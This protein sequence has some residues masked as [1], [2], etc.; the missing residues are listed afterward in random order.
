MQSQRFLLTLAAAAALAG[1]ASA[2]APDPRDPWEPLNRATFQVNDT[3]DRAVFKPLAQGYRFVLPSPIRTG[4]R[5]VFANLQDPWIAVNQLLQGKA[6]DALSDLWRFIA[7]STFGLG[8]V[9][10]IATDM[11]MPKHNEDFGQTLAVWGVGFG[12][13]LVL[14]ILGPSTVRDAAGTGVGA[15]VDY[16]PWKIPK[17]FNFEHRVAW[18]NSLFALDFVQLRASLLDTTAALE[19]AALDPYAFLRGAYFQRRR[20]LIYDGNPPP[21]DASDKPSPEPPDEP[22]PDAPRGAAD[23]TPLPA[24][25][26]DLR[27][28]APDESARAI[29][30]KVPANYE[31]VLEAGAGTWSPPAESRILQP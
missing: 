15:Y 7:N 18:Q 1:C 23:P 10:D 27:G 11:R 13:Y 30:P 16:L 25:T 9:F 17:W 20:N 3:L 28:G 5:N 24:A 8:G 29:E 31:A 14:P 2:R 4:V 26:P 19:Q 12:P 22:E 6:D 21:A